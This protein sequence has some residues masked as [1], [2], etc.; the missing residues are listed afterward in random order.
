MTGPD[1]YQGDTLG[2]DEPDRRTRRNVVANVIHVLP[3]RE[4]Y[5]PVLQALLAPGRPVRKSSGHK[6]LPDVY[7]ARRQWLGR[8]RIWIREELGREP[9]STQISEADQRAYENA[10]GDIWQ[11]SHAGVE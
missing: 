9:F 7:E 10:T 8:C 3:E 4:D 11:A 6:A 1:T 5:L 2:A